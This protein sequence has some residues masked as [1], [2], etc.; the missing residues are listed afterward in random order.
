MYKRPFRFLNLEGV[1]NGFKKSERSPHKQAHFS[2]YLLEGNMQTNLSFKRTMIY[3]A[4]ISVISWG[5]FI[6]VFRSFWRG[7]FDVGESLLV[8]WLWLIVGTAAFVG[9]TFLVFRL[10]Q[11]P[12]KWKASAAIAFAAPALILDVFAT[13]FF[14]LWYPNGTSGDV[15]IYPALILGGTGFF[16]L[17]ILFSSAPAEA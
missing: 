3:M 7:T 16:L 8:F 10:L 4:I 5:A 13:L 1:K 9:F 2:T 11:I 6:V 12:K 14:E 17:S 15:R